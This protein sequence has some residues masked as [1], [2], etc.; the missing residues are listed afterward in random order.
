MSRMRLQK[1]RRTQIGIGAIVRTKVL[2]SGCGYYAVYAKLIPILYYVP[3][4]YVCFVIDSIYYIITTLVC[5]TIFNFNS[6][7]TTAIRSDRILV[8]PV[9]YIYNIHIG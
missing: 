8:M 3:R 7:A 2:Y 4:S 6:T 9:S 5:K 1:M